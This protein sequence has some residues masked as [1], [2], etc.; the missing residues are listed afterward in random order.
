MTTDPLQQAR[1]ALDR[2]E[3]GQVLRLLEPLCASYP[4]T[5]PEGGRLRLLMATAL[6]GQ[7]RTDTA[8]ACCRSL[9]G[10]H[11]QQLR[12]QARDLL[13]VLEAPELNRPREWSLTLPSLASA[14]P[15]ERLSPGRRRQSRA[16]APEP[17]APP[18]VGPLEAPR[19]FAAVVVA[20]LLSVLLS[21]LL[22]GCMRVRS[23]IHFAG[24]GRLQIS[25]ALRPASGSPSPLQ[26]R[27]VEALGQSR[28]GSFQ[29]HRQ[30]AEEILQTPVLAAPQALAALGQSLN[31]IGELAA[32]PLP[33]PT[34]ELRER[35]WLVGVH[36]HLLLDLDLTAVPN[37]PG[38]QLEVLLDPV[39]A[40]DVRRAVPLAT[41][42]EVENSAATAPRKPGF[43]K[44]LG[45]VLWPLQSGRRNTLEL[46]CWR[47]SPLG[48]G[49]LVIALLLMLSLALQRLRLSLG[50]G[51]PELPA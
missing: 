10:C 20:L 24:P 11:D 26:Q 2:G 38:L 32:T 43:G 3:Y 42:S 44:R 45:R 34:L 7:G 50:F 8:A 37:L 18:P 15:L 23:E 39:A 36:Q 22:G 9:Q 5:S 48:L 33:P 35:N 6:M 49:S 25:H 28:N 12:H 27:F 47:W 13:Q 4:A 51:L 46:D 17:E 21:Q 29:R 41:R 40:G 31:L 1:V 16:T 19:G 30:G 14:P